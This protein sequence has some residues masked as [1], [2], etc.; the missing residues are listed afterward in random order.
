MPNQISPTTTGW[1]FFGTPI[2]LA[3]LEAVAWKEVLFGMLNELDVRPVF[4]NSVVP[5]PGTFGVSIFTTVVGTFSEP[6]DPVSFGTSFF[7]QKES[8]G[9]LVPGNVVFSDS[10]RVFEFTPDDPLDSLAVY[11]IK[12]FEGLMGKRSNTMVEN[13]DEMFVT[14]DT[15]APFVVAT[16][17]TQGATG[18]PRISQVTIDFSEPINVG[19]AISAFSMQIDSTAQVLAGSFAFASTEDSLT[20]TPS[21][22]L[23]SRE[24]IIVGLE[25]GRWPV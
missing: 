3:S 14:E 13:F 15:V 20:F 24:L 5:A 22:P 4:V 16:T 7:L 21:T 25:V 23:P 1:D 18:V 10:D 17:P 8:S 12:I 19:S 2:D 9:L 11:R 6:V